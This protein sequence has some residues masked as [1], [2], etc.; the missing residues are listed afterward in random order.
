VKHKSKIG[1][2][3]L[4]LWRRTNGLWN[5]EIRSR[6]TFWVVDIALGEGLDRTSAIR[7]AIRIIREARRA[8]V[9]SSHQMAVAL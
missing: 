9:A 3:T 7:N 4:E 6:V 1:R 2:V 8:R 5:C